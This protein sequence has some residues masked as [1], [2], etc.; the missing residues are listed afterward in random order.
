LRRPSAGW[1]SSQHRPWRSLAPATTKRPVAEP[2]LWG[3]L[4]GTAATGGTDALWFTAGINHEQDGLLGV[5][6]P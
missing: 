6:R 3:L 4:P 2:G 1:L 5:L